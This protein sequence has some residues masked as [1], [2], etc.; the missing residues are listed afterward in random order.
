MG[1]ANTPIPNRGTVLKYEIFISYETEAI[2]PLHPPLNPGTH[3]HSTG[4]NLLTSHLH[5]NSYNLLFQLSV[6]RKE[7]HDDRSFPMIWLSANISMILF[8]LNKVTIIL[9]LILCGKET[10]VDVS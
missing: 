3:M 2:I 10:N 8:K 4:V 1:K 6:Y 7:L 9:N 5:Y